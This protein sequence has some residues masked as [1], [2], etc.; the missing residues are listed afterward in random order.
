M[1]LAPGIVTNIKVRVRSSRSI[2]VTWLAAK[3]SGSGIIGHD[4]LYNR[5]DKP[6]I[7][8]YWKIH[9]VN[10]PL[11]FNV[12]LSNLLPNR[13]YEIKI[14]ARSKEARGVPSEVVKAKTFEDGK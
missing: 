8:R 13:L 6:V 7:E 2:E 4:L 11:Q 10:N 14:Y 9:T 3:N 12:T 1:I 5:G